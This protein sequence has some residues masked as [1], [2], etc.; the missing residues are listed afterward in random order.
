MGG[1]LGGS[2]A[3]DNIEGKK[4][5]VTDRTASKYRD[6]TNTLNA[7]AQ[8]DWHMQVKRDIQTHNKPVTEI[9]TV[10]EENTELCTTE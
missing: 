5:V 4:S 6:L 7:L 9:R 8:H 2:T 1:M 10:A 3:I